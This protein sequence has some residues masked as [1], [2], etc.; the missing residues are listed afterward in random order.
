MFFEPY[1]E[2]GVSVSDLNVMLAK[3]EAIPRLCLLKKRGF[4]TLGR[5]MVSGST[6]NWTKRS[7]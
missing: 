7:E 1:S 3:K 6:W 2:R 5:N 4:D